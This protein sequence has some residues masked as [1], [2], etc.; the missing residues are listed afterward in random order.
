VAYSGITKNFFHILA[1]PS[2]EIFGLPE[3]RESSSFTQEL[4]L[5]KLSGS[6]DVL[7]LE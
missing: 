3:C 1:M 4:L 5:C 2:P 6:S 7:N